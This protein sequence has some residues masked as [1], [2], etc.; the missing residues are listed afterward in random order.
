MRA[1][2]LVFVSVFLSFA[3]PP[4]CVP[5]APRELL[6]FFATTDALT[7]S[8]AALRPPTG[9]NSVVPQAD[10]PDSCARLSDHSVSNHLRIVRRSRRIAPCRSAVARESCSPRQASPFARRL[11]QSRRPNRVHVVL[12]PRRTLLRTGPSRPVAPHL[13]FPQRSYGSIP[14]A[15]QRTE[16]DFH[17]SNRAPF[18]AHWKASRCD[19]TPAY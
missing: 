19:V 5:F 15:S 9:M 10:L 18:Q 17:H 3:L 14:H 8:W 4:S 12:H 13:V 7:S 11:A 16:V 6:R 2:A 1:L